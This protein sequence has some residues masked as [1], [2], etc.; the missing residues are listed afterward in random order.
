MSFISAHSRE[1]IL[2]DINKLFSEFN[3]QI[4]A[5]WPRDIAFPMTAQKSKIASLFY[6]LRL[7][8]TLSLLVGLLYIRLC[9]AK[10]TP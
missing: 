7:A 3:E 10:R 5:F 4:L 8:P 6:S 9:T 2:R 1:C